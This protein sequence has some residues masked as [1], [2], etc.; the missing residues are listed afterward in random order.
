M[1]LSNKYTSWYNSIIT[2]A[3]DTPRSKKNTSIYY[4]FHHIIPRSLG[5][6]NK[7][8]NLVLLT[9]KEH[10]VCHLLLV[11][12]TSSLDRSKM[13][14]AF[15]L[16]QK[17]AQ[18]NKRYHSRLYETLKTHYSKYL[19]R[20]GMKGS[21]N[22]M[23]GKESA[24]K[25]KTHS[26]ETKSTIS[27]ARKGK[28]TTPKGQPKTSEHRRKISEAKLGKSN[29]SLKGKSRSDETKLKISQA[30]SGRTKPPHT[31]DTKRKQ[32]EAARLRW[33]KIKS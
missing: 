30:L 20:E 33:S 6:S 15:M 18:K 1:F 13:A 29:P 23:F 27:T 3:K 12:M 21:S 2:R 4:E 8:E 19:H 17:N 24:F 7:K 9:A 28:A 10:F 5:G 26:E 25:G 22:P 16:M 14:N 11:K 31:E 32:S